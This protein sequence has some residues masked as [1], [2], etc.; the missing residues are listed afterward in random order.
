VAQGE[1]VGPEQEHRPDDVSRQRIA[2]SNGVREQQV[3]L[4]PRGLR[5]LDE[6]GGQV[7]EAGRHSVDDLAGR[8]E[9]FYDLASLGH[10]GSRFVAQADS[11]PAAGHGL[12]IRDREIRSGEHD[13]G[14]LAGRLAQPMGFGQVP[15][16]GRIG[17]GGIAHKR[18]IA[19]PLVS[20]PQR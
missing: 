3:L 18:S 20:G 1:G 7:P 6:R 14:L 8:N 4:Q 16:G 5:R 13:L 17:S 15:M 2:D 12:D 11:P 9:P 19:T 10:A